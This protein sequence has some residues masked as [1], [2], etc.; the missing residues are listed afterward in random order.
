[1]RAKSIKP[2]KICYLIA[3]L[4]VAVSGCADDS[5]D[6]PR[7]AKETAVD[8]TTRPLGS[9]LM[10]ELEVSCKDGTEINESVSTEPECDALQEQAQ[11]FDYNQCTVIFG[12]EQRSVKQ[13]G[14]E[15]TL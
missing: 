4:I 8:L 5:P 1:M 11:T 7:T 10:C 9:A 13:S 15:S 2:M 14:S 12:K 3:C 6:G